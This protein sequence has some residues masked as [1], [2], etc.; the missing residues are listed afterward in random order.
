MKLATDVRIPAEVTRT[1]AWGTLVLLAAAFLVSSAGAQVD[2]SHPKLDPILRSAILLGD[3]EGPVSVE[4]RA[5]AVDGLVTGYNVFIRGAV[6][7]A[8]LE[9]LGVDVRTDLGDIKTAWIPETAL[10]DVLALP[11]VRQVQGCA[12]T[13]PELEISVPATGVSSLRGAGPAFTGLNGQGIIWGDVD[14]GIDWTHADFKDPAGLTRI[15]FLWDQTDALGPAPGAFGYGS[16]WTAAQID[17]G[18][19]RETDPSAHGTHVAG[20]GAG[21]GSATGNGQPAFQYVGMAPLADIVMVKTDF[22]TAGVVDGVNYVFQTAAAQGQLA[23]CN[24]SL[25]SHYGPHDGTSTF[26]QALSSLTGPG[27]V[28]AKSAGNEN[29]SNIHAEVF[30]TPA[31]GYARLNVPSPSS[32]ANTFIAVDGYYDQL[33]NIAVS[34]V[35]ANG[36]VLGPVARGASLVQT[37]PGQG[38]AY[39]ENGLSPTN[40]GDYE[41]YVELS[42]NGAAIASGNWDIFVYAVSLGAT[43]EV[44]LWRF[45]ENV[46]GTP[47][48]TSGAQNDELVSEPGNA[49]SICTVASWTS[50]RYWTSIDGNSYNFTGAVNPGNLSPF[51][52]PGP[53]RDGRQKPDI[54][55]PG[56]AIVAARSAQALPAPAAALVVPD[57][58]HVANQGTSMAAPHVTG[59]FA[60]LLQNRGA[61]TTSQA[62]QLL[63]SNALVDAYTGPVWN[64]KWGF[65][66]LYISQPVPAV[67]EAVTVDATDGVVHLAWRVGEGSTVTDFRALRRILGEEFYSPVT[68]AI[69]QESFDGGQ[70]YG[71]DD[72]DVLPG[73]TYQYQLS[74]VDEDGQRVVFGPYVAQVPVKSLAWAFARPAPNPLRGSAVFSFTAGSRGIASLSIY[75]ARGRLIARP[76]D[77]MVD[78]GPHTVA[79]NATA[80]DGSRLARGVYLAVFRGGGIAA[81]EKLLILE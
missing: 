73:L 10:A 72:A 35:T 66:K 77:Q 19:C 31:G 33:D 9:A 54:A 17:A 40:S 4:S 71:L 75:D 61:I 7:A 65:G 68:A 22:S 46:P 36:T 2:A 23:A 56:S 41:I 62:C 64:N 80:D 26:E 81:R 47:R 21:D 28:L 58:V 39:V 37:V 67:L 6:T 13:E 18:L 25:G 76:L 38:T 43:G 12:R 60:L 16:E 11:G 14:S 63:A 51:S 5:S 74:G 32:A 45:Y 15:K 70:H 30:A 3:F 29:N 24:L 49:L 48:F 52:S 50:K 79:W 78:A 34:L 57:G 42:S 20:I 44:D 27:K 55:A 8:E 1:V 59:A 69:R 53:T